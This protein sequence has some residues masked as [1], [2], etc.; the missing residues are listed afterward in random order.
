MI[1]NKWKHTLVSL[2]AVG[3]F[4]TSYLT[5]THFKSQILNCLG[6][7]VVNG[8]QVVTESI[9]STIL[10]VPIA[11]IGL[12]YYLFVI[13]VALLSYKHK[14][15]FLL[16]SLLPLT[17]LSSIF[18]LRLIYLQVNVIGYICYYCMLSA[19][20]SFILF[21]ISYNIY[22]KINNVE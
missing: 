16:N 15:N 19:V 18:S 13:G 10:G 11:L 12:C 9:Y 1:E 14:Y 17:A 4:D 3:L 2:S 5:Y 6:F 21:G 8:C 22:Q 7:A 20:I